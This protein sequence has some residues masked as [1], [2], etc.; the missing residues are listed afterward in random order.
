MREVVTRTMQSTASDSPHTYTFS[1][2]DS[3]C[4]LHTWS[5]ILDNGAQAW[6]YWQFVTSGTGYALE[7]GYWELHPRHIP[8]VFGDW[9]T[10]LWRA[11]GWS[12]ANGNLYANGSNT[13]VCDVN[14]TNVQWADSTQVLDSYGNLTAKYLYSYNNTSSTM[15]TYYLYYLTDPNYTSRHITN[16]LTSASVI[17]SSGYWT[18]LVQNTYDQYSTSCG[19]QSGLVPH[20]PCSTKAR[21]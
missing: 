20:S 10:L 19:G 13:A 3:C 6:K 2:D 1:H 15:L 11:T 12:T 18:N 8:A 5:A 9:T 21:E 17:P 16:R 14:D 7:S 4:S